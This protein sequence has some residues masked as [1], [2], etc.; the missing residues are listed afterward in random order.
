MIE[1]GLLNRD[2]AALLSKMGHG[3]QFLLCD[4]GFAIPEGLPVVDLSIAVNMPTVD[5]VLKEVL[6]FFSVE[7]VIF[8][9]EQRDACP[10]KLERLI[11]LFDPPIEQQTISHV[12]L[13]QRSRSVKGVIRTGDF[14][15]FTNLILVSGAGDR[16]IFEQSGDN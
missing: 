5:V 11:A 15:A 14:S 9:Q 12:E 6:K 3:D 8:A 4:A 10:A 7:K 16:W 13:K 1:K 2:L